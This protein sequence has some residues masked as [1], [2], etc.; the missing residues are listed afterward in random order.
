MPILTVIIYHG[1]HNNKYDDLDNYN[2]LT[3]LLKHHL[4]LYEENI[5]KYYII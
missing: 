4:T 1:C 3:K 5:I 2:S